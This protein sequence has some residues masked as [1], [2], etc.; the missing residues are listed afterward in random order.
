[1]IEAFY[2]AMRQNPDIQ[3]KAYREIMSV[4]GSE[5]LPGLSDRAAL[6]YVEALYREVFRWMPPVPFSLPHSSTADDI[7][8]GYFIPK[9]DPALF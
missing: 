9:G 4:V 6:P 7:Y 8:K 5:R 2:V 3:D 1:M